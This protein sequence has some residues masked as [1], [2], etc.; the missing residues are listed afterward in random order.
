MTTALLVLAGATSTG[1]IA[2][3]LATRYRAARRTNP[4]VD[5]DNEMSNQMTTKPAA[6]PKIV[7]Q[8][9]WAAAQSELLTKEKELTRAYDAL[10]AERRRMPMVRI[11]KEYVFDGPEGR[12]TLLDLF[13]GRCQLIVYHFMFGPNWDAGCV[14]CSMLTDSI[15]P[16][17]HVH[18]RDASLV[19]ISRAPLEKLTEYRAR[20]GWSVPWYSSHNSDFNFDFGVSHGENEHHGLSVFLRDGD[21][22]FRTY[23]TTDRGCDRL[24][25]NLNYLDLTPFGRQETWENSPE[26]WPQSEPYVWWRRH[27]EYDSE[28]SPPP[29][30]ERNE[31]SVL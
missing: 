26:G 19:L 1:G 6:L 9:E 20:M 25:F 2:A 16:L 14:G 24:N 28:T 31:Q 13:D 10:A 8:D 5:T 15:G 21:A 11:E 18:A 29:S 7:S 23:S 12:S 4:H 27:D 3:V 30:R 22:V 17:E